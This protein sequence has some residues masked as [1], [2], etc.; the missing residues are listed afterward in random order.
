MAWVCIESSLLL[1]AKSINFYRFIAD[2]WVYKIFSMQASIYQIFKFVAF[3]N[4]ISGILLA[5]VDNYAR[6]EAAFLLDV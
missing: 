6:K 4:D 5:F 3:K 1:H 2:E